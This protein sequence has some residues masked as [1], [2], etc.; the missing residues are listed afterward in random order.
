MAMLKRVAVVNVRVILSRSLATVPTYGVLSLR[1]KNVQNLLVSSKS[2]ATSGSS[3][4]SAASSRKQVTIVNDDGRVQWQ[5]L[6]PREKAART[7]Q[8]TFNLGL[9][10]AGFVGTGLVA[11]FLYGEVFASDS[12]TAFF[13][14]AVDRVRS[15]PRALE[16]LGARK[17]VEAYGE[18]TSNKWARARPIASSTHKDSTGIEHFR[19]HFN[20]EGSERKGVVSLHMVKGPGH[21]DYEYRFLALDVPGYPRYYLENAHA[22]KEKRPAGFRMLGVQWR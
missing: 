22:P 14:R 3:R 2:Y 13:N 21:P 17:T 12:K 16:L 7:T 15:D 4:N 18:P 6:S 9:V 20:V 1:P 8:Q 10:L 19:M 5:D 11:Y